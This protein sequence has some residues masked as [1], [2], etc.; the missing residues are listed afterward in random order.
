MSLN[1]PNPMSTPTESLTEGPDDGEKAIS[2]QTDS[3]PISPFLKS[4]ALIFYFKHF[5]KIAWLHTKASCLG[6]V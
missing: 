6:E 3:M 2:S 4:E 5:L 1:G